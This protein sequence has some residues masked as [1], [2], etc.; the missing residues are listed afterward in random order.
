MK[1]VSLEEANLDQCVAD[2]Q[3]DSVVILR[4]GEPM[5]LLVD[6]RGLDMEQLELARSAEFWD[7][8]RR[9]RAEPKISRVELERRLNQN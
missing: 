5:A 6:V 4:N 9:R 8:I 7:M 1:V 3:T 2:A